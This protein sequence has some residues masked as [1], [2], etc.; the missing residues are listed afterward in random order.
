MKEKELVENHILY[1][2]SSILS[3]FIKQCIIEDKS[4][5]D[6]NVLEW[7]LVTSSLVKWLKEENEVFIEYFGCH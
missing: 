1:N 6:S 2:Q 3:E 4:I 5:Y 7:W